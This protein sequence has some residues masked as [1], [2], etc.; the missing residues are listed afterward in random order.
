MKLSVELKNQFSFLFQFFRRSTKMK[1][2]TDA[3]NGKGKKL[4]WPFDVF[5]VNFFMSL[6]LFFSPTFC[7]NQSSGHAFFSLF[8][9]TFSMPFRLLFTLTAKSQGQTV[10]T[11]HFSCLR[12]LKPVTCS[13]SVSQS[14]DY[15]L[16]L[17]FFCFESRLNAKSVWWNEINFASKEHLP[18]M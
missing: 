1:N 12:P 4:E 16:I 14:L 13:S 6:S 5:L 3:R 15:G 17:F 2:L 7:T 18:N 9:R 8:S 10:I 11:C